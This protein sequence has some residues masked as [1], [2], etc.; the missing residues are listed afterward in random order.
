MFQRLG[1]VFALKQQA[2]SGGLDRASP[3][4]Q[5]PEVGRLGELLLATPAQSFLVS[6]PE[7]LMT[8]NDCFGHQKQ[9]KAGYINQTQQK[10]HVGVKTKLLKRHVHKTLHLLRKEYYR[11]YKINDRT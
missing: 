6:G 2:Y 1:S 5:I 11:Y 8:H 3:Y 9:H 10:P 4:L 7:G